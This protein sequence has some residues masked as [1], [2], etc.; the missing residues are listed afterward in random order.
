MTGLHAIVDFILEADRLKSV[1]RKIRVPGSERYENSAEHS[2][3]LALFA[4]SLT[5]DADS[6]LDRDRV[7]RML[8][9][10]DL[11]EIETGDTLAFIEEGQEARKLAERTA[12]A[13]L[14]ARLPV[15]QGEEFLALWEEFEREETAEAHFA[16]A[17]DRAMPVLINLANE[18]QSWRENDVSYERVVRR[19]R[20]P[21]ERG[22]PALWAHIA[23]RLLAARE[24]GWFGG[25]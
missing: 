24:R 5:T 11:G 21:I 13:A 1:T 8:L 22:C 18:G 7:V 14:F 15:D 4:L 19:I 16:H 10:H 20:P 2:W 3:Q 6:A 17:V 12:V 23:P 25:G 9:V